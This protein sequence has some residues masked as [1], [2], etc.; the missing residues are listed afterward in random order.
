M[1][2]LVE[3]VVK[4][5]AGHPDQVTVVETEAEGA[6]QLRLT[7]AEEDKGRIIGKEGKVIKAIRSLLGPSASK[8]GK[9]AFLDI[10]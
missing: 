3:F 4:K 5:L 7:V 6:V 8:S 10:E 2:T 9:R 1:K